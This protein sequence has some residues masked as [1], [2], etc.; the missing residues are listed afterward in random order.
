MTVEEKL[1]LL[2]GKIDT[3]QNILVE[4]YEATPFE[5]REYSSLS[6]ETQLSLERTLRDVRNEIVKLSVLKDAAYKAAFNSLG[7]EVSVSKQKAI[8]T[9]DKEYQ[10]NLVK[11]TKMEN[12]K[13]YL[14]GMI[15]I[16]NNAH[17]FFKSQMDG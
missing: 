14:K 13:E 4:K 11:L 3:I 15:S 8:A 1:A 12:N 7:N 10:I 6:L 17:H 2:E 9:G 16:C 5:A